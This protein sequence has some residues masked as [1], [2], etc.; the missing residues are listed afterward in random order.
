[1]PATDVT[2]LRKKLRRQ[3]YAPIPVNGKKPP[4]EGWTEK[5]ETSDDEIELWRSLFPN[6]TNTGVL[7]RA[8]PGL[9]IDLLDEAAAAAIE[10]LA[11]ERFGERGCFLVRI[12]KAPKRLIPLRTDAPFKK[13]TLNL[14]AG[15]DRAGDKI[16]V[17]GDGQQMVVAGNHP[18]TKESYRWFGGALWDVA[19]DELPLVTEAELR[20]FVVAAGE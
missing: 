5:I 2:A 19:A 14:I 4:L 3:G 16:E 17:L 13:I 15:N 9:D 10:A 11:K 7:A 1:M 18:D 6:A 12:G 20:A 8:T